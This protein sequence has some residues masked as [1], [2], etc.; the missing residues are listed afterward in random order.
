MNGK[1]VVENC[2]VQD[3]DEDCRRW[4]EDAVSTLLYTIGEDPAREGL[5][6]TPKRVVKA[7]KEMTSGYNDDPR[8]ILGTCFQADYDQMVVLKGISFTSVC[9]HHLLPFVGTAAVGYIPSGK[10]VGLSKLARVTLC[11]AKRLQLQEQ[12]TTQIANAINDALSPIGVGVV[13]SAA[14]QCMACR[15]VQMSGATMVTSALLGQM[16]EPEVRAEF[17]RLCNGITGH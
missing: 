17:L 4:A 10:V 1:I 11:F 9:E 3:D 16:R 8:E 2:Y 15:G 13:I 7:L 14:H 5:I 6:D 12:M